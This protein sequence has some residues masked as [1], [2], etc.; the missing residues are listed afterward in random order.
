MSRHPFTDPISGQTVTLVNRPDRWW[1]E[2]GVGVEHGGC[3]LLADVFA[4]LD[5][6]SCPVCG[7]NG[8]VGGAWVV[9]IVEAETY[10]PT[11]EPEPPADL[12]QDGRR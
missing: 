8:R 10:P 1:W 2:G 4:D 6:F 5:C 7:W 12:R 3:N 11:A 9:D